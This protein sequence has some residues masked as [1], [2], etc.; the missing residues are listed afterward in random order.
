VLDSTLSRTRLIAGALLGGAL[1]ITSLSCG[2]SQAETE[3]QIQQSRDAEAKAAAAQ[4]AAVKAQDAANKATAVVD[5]ARKA[6][7]DAAA[8]ID[9]VSRHLDQL[10]RERQEDDDD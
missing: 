1:A 2:P 3:A 8:E 5:H 9:R 6:V 10:E 7:D 4:E